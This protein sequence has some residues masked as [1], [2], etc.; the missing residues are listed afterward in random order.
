MK[1]NCRN[2]RLALGALVVA[3]AG[4][5]GRAE[6]GCDADGNPN[7]AG[8]FCYKLIGSD[9][10]FEIMGAAITRAQA[11]GVSNSSDL[12]YFG[13]G[14]GNGETALTGNNGSTTPAHLGYQSIAPMSRNFRPKFVDATG[15]GAD[16]SRRS[17]SNPGG[18]SHPTWA[19]SNANVV[20][21]DAAVF[22]VDTTGGGT[23]SNINFLTFNDNTG[24]LS[25]TNV[26]KGRKNDSTLT[27]A[28]GTESLSRVLGDQAQPQINYSNVMSVVLSGVDGSGTI[29][30]CSD[31]RRLQAVQDL[32]NLLGATTIDHLYRRDDNS[33]TTDTFK[34]RIMV[35]NNT[36]NS[37]AGY[38]YTGGR[39]CNGAGTG[40]NK[41]TAFYKGLC[42]VTRATAC[43]KDSNCPAGEKCWFNLNNQDFDPIRRICSPSTVGIGPEFASATMA[44]TTC[45][46]MIH[47]KACI[48]GDDANNKYC[49]NGSTP[50]SAHCSKDSDCG[51][52]SPLGTCT[53]L[54][55]QGLI[56]ALSDTDPGSN[57]I[58]LSIGNRVA[59]SSGRNMGFAGRTATRVAGV[60]G[61]YIN[62]I[63]PDANEGGD[64]AVRQGG[65]L[66][67][68]RLFIQ[69]AYNRTGTGYDATWDAPDD[70][71]AYLGSTGGGNRQLLAEQALWNNYLSN[72]T[73][74]DPIV[75]RFD[76][77]RCASNTNTNCTNA[78]S[79]TPVSG[80]PACEPCDGADPQYEVSPNLCADPSFAAVPSPLGAYNP[81]QAPLATTGMAIT[82]DSRGRT[83][84]G[85]ALVQFAAA[86]GLCLTGKTATGGVCTDADPRQQYAP[87][88]QSLDC[89][90]GLSCKNSQGHGSTGRNYGLY[91]AP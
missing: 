44:P 35:V 70:L 38:A 74:M 29:A 85:T 2:P 23:L 19:P 27:T 76:F 30:A 72:R 69:N 42:S 91:C 28:Y 61:L 14:S 36:G 57:D 84:N 60:R 17:A 5:A 68:R 80:D 15:A 7:P 47:G 9:T 16:F 10:L 73:L 13:T 21:L 48:G 22:L 53:D 12:F 4:I 3:I 37:L 43:S 87:C 75:R 78:C 81:N 24:S 67:A 6:A 64:D 90:S 63:S 40:P 45:T 71:A 77:I 52:G 31:P 25:T 8:S 50:Y 20:G 56:V 18:I 46:D 26:L 89:I 33:G 41:D 55:T 49:A 34:D 1:M 32:A 39:F 88:S 51:T 79:G 86:S 59:N 66:L 58:T 82:A 54:C 83:W 11:A 65:Y 62:T